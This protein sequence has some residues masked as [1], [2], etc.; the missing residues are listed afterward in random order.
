MEQ[1]QDIAFHMHDWEN[2]N[3]EIIADTKI[4]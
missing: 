1:V 3:T 4:V 2:D